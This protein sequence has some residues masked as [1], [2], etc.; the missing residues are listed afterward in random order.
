VLRRESTKHPQFK[1]TGESNEGADHELGKKDEQSSRDEEASQEM[2]ANTPVKAV[3]S[4]EKRKGRSKS[5]SSDPADDDSDKN[6]IDDDVP[7]SFPQRVSGCVSGHICLKSGLLRCD[8][9]GLIALL[10]AHI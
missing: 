8:G 7:L 4:E 6:N 9:I 3:N 1:M 5:H 10:S 2:E